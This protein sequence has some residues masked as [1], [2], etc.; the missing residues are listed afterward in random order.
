M[1]VPGSTPSINHPSSVFFA[2]E[3]GVD[4]KILGA[5]NYPKDFQ[6][7]LI[8]SAI[9]GNLFIYKMT[10]NPETFHVTLIGEIVTEENAIAETRTSVYVFVNLFKNVRNCFQRADDTVEIT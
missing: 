7:C 2:A 8:P 1:T 5:F 10:R 3:S 6:L 9:E 4:S